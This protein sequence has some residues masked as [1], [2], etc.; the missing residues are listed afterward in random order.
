VF[1][2]QENKGLKEIPVFLTYRVHKDRREQLDLVH[3]VLGVTKA[4]KELKEPTEDHKGPKVVRVIKGRRATKVIKA[5]LV[6]KACRAYL[7]FQALK[8]SKDLLVLEHKV[9]RVRLL[10]FK[11]LKVSMVD[12]REPRVLPV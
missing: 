12:L 9:R 6:H 7:T 2:V 10:P 1:R 3:K 5:K 11:D 4:I 8:E